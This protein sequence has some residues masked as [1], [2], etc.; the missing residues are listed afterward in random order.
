MANERKSSFTVRVGS[1][2]AAGVQME[3]V[4]FSVDGSSDLSDSAHTETIQ[5]YQGLVSQYLKVLVPILEKS[6]VI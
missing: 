1:L 6:E 2:N 3:N 5:F 4:E